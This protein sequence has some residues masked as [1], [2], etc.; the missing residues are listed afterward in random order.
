M[1]LYKIAS[2]QARPS[3]PSRYSGLSQSTYTQG[4]L[5]KDKTDEFWVNVIRAGKDDL[6]DFEVGECVDFDDADG[7]TIYEDDL[8][9]ER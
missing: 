4:L 5:L 3:I 6:L 2:K 7:W 9:R 8:V 1:S